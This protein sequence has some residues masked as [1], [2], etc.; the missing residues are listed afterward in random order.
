MFKGYRLAVVVPAY[1][2][3]QR[4]ERVLENMPQIV[5]AVIVVDD[6]STDQTAD[7]AAA[8]KDSRVRVIRHKVNQ[9]VGGAMATGLSGALEIGADLIVKMDGDGQMN[10]TRL[11]SLLQPLVDEEYGYAKGNRFLHSN[12]LMWMPR[13]RLFGNFILTF[14]TKLSSGYW[15]IF[16]P[17][18]GYIA[19]RADTLKALNLHGLS[20]GYFFENDM[21]VRLNV[22]NV[23]IKDV[24]MPAIYNGNHS[25]M[26]ISRVLVAFPF[27]LFQRFWKRIYEKYVLRDF[28]AIAAFY[29]SG[30]LLL[31]WGTIFGGITWSISIIHN[32]DA[33]TG[34]VMLSVLPFLM[35][36][37]LVLQAITLEMHSNG[38]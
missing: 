19:I 35:G 20:R 30:F 26:S 13:H 10:P 11:E 22:C 33:S 21:L 27:Y 5:D 36:F 4:I 28:S 24:P 23:R 34:T 37:Q 25:S 38:K 3:A 29:I 32:T 15:H 1:N 17:Q 6:F 7:R 8:V 16:D 9:G 31:A 14:L 18:N 12:E 2:E